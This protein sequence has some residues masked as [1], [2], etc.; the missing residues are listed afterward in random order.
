MKGV[1]RTSLKMA[2]AIATVVGIPLSVFM[3]MYG[4]LFVHSAIYLLL[5]LTPGY[6]YLEHQ[7]GFPDVPL[8]SVLVYLAGQWLYH[9]AVV[10]SIL[11][12]INKLTRN[13][14]I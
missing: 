6:F 4:Y 12:L 13:R 3:M 10:L 2:L 7:V 5:V 14:Y 1:K 9:F 8:V 11:W